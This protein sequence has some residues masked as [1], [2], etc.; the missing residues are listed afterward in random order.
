[1]NQPPWMPFAWADL[2]QH[3]IAGEGTN[4]R[5]AEYFR[6][7]GHPEITDDET[8]WCAAFVGACLEQS[9]I[10]VAEYMTE[11][12]P[13]KLLERKLQDAIQAARHRLEKH[14]S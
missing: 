8:A 4:P 12:P 1:M 3:E 7:S 14:A 5:I 2:G 10:R 6:L 9:G 13:R 11:L